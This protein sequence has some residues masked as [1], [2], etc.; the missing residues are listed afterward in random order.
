M[1]S[2]EVRNPAIPQHA[3]WRGVYEEVAADIVGNLFH[4]KT[5]LWFVRICIELVQRAVLFVEK[6]HAGRV[7]QR[8]DV[9]ARVGA[10]R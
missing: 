7:V 2:S 8:V 10:C 6:A 5:A 4:T 3:L 9:C 1:K